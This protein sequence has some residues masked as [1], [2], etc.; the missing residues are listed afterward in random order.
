M[1]ARRLILIMLAL[2]V[3]SSIAAALVPIDRAAL[4]D[5][6]TTTVVAEPERTGGRHRARVDLGT[7][8][9]RRIPVR[10]GDN[11]TLTVTGRSPGLVEV[12]GLG[13]TENVD[14]DAPAVFDLRPYATGEYPVRLLESGRRIAVIEVSRAGRR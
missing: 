9:V 6:S 2:L 4:R 3:L 1:A 5:T 7:E 12:A 13:Q 11:L 8:R 14:P 10:L